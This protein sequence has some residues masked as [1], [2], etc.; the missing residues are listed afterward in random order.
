LLLSFITY[1]ASCIFH[2]SHPFCGI[3]LPYS[4][5]FYRLPFY[6]SYNVAGISDWIALCPPII[7]QVAV[8]CTTFLYLSIYLP[9]SEVMDHALRT[10]SYIAD[11][12]SLVVLMAR[13]RPR[14]HRTDVTVQ[15]A[16]ASQNDLP[17]FSSLKGPGHCSVHWTSIPSGIYGIPQSQWHRGSL[18]RR[19]M[20][21]KF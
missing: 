4:S 16:S 1:S 2:D 19:E 14:S 13:R 3:N 8:T 15:S 17:C 5:S 6:I 12:G 21:L 10:I 18:V 9:F 11:I 7:A 20:D